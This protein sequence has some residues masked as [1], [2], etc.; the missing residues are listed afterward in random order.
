MSHFN[1]DEKECCADTETVNQQACSAKFL[2]K[3]FFVVNI[4]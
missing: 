2:H 1:T 3:I 4:E